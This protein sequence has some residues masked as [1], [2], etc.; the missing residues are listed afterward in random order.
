MN[1]IRM[2]EAALCMVCMCAVIG[3]FLLWRSSTQAIAEEVFNSYGQFIASVSS[4]V[5]AAS[6]FGIVATFVHTVWMAYLSVAISV[7]V[8]FFFIPSDRIVLLVMAVC[9][10][11]AL[12]AL[13]RVRK[14]ASLSRGFNVANMF[15]SGVPLF[16]TVFGIVI[17][18]RK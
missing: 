18:V 2:K 16:L 17:S 11:L 8:P 6:L 15:K 7:T 9:I 3:S 12:F 13:R 1:I 4:L 5:L 10:L 14:D